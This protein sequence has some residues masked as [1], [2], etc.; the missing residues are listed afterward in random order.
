[1]STAPS[2]YARS[3]EEAAQ[4][5]KDSLA[6]PREGWG[7]IT[8]SDS[9]PI[10]GGSWTDTG[11]RRDRRQLKQRAVG[12]VRVV[13]CPPPLTRILNHHL[14][15]LGV[16][17]DGRLFRN[18]T[19]GDLAESTLSRTWDKARKAALTPDEYTSPLAR[20]PYDLRH[21]C[22]SFWLAVGVP[23]AQV[24]EWAGHSITVL[25]QIYAKVIAGLENTARKRIEHGLNTMGTST[26]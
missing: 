4:L 6:L 12:E 15:T 18:L 21:A 26:T 3:L 16:T 13:P 7:E 20:R 10:A 24:A 1:M 19:G 8:L 9:A 5:T 25:L 14:D 22:V 2:T 11:N 17:A 23:A